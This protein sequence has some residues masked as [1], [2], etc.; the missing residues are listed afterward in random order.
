MA[1]VLNPAV[2][3]LDQDP[4]RLGISP[5]KGCYSAS[6]DPQPS[7]GAGPF[8]VRLIRADPAT[9]A[10]DHD[11]EG[12]TVSEA[13][14][15]QAGTPQG[16]EPRRAG[17]F[18]FGRGAALPGG[19]FGWLGADGT[20]DETQPCPLLHQRP[21]DPR[22]RA[23]PPAGGGRSGRPG[24]VRTWRFA[25]RY[26]DPVNGGW[27]S[28]VDIS[29]AGHRFRQGELRARARPAGGVQRHGR[30]DTRRR[31]RPGGRGRAIEQHFW[32][33]ADGLRR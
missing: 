11:Q 21:D 5:W 28:E 8:S 33:E 6:R 14:T 12:K 16:D 30:G 29:G 32:S 10:R 15:A 7:P 1:A 23:R 17:C 24:G 19:G 31:D 9:A 27:F 2:T 13:R 4:A 20:L 22:L 25:S 26:A 18:A 3:V